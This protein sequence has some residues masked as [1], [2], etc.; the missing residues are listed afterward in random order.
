VPAA[1]LPFPFE[2]NLAQQHFLRKIGEKLGINWEEKI[3]RK[4]M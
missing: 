2:N 3:Y 4:N 1:G